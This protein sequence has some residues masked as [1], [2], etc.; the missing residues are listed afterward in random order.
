MSLEN[1]SPV[2]KEELLKGISKIIDK[3]KVAEKKASAKPVDDVDVVDI[4][5]EGKDAP[6]AQ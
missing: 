5:E 1:M 2:F 6:A 3:P 4:S